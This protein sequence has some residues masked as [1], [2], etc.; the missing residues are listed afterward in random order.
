V[1]NSRVPTAE[2]DANWNPVDGGPGVTGYRN[3]HAKKNGTAG[4]LD[5]MQAPFD[6]AAERGMVG[7]ILLGCS[8]DAIRE[9]AGR[10]DIH[11]TL[12]QSAF[13]VLAALAAEDEPTNDVQVFIGKAKEMHLWAGDDAGDDGINTLFIAKLIGDLPHGES[14]VFHAKRVAE[15]SRLRQLQTSCLDVLRLVPSKTSEQLC[16]HL[17][18]R[19]ETIAK[20]CYAGPKVTMMDTIEATE[21]QWLW[22]DRFVR[23]K[24]NIISGEPGVGK[25]FLVCDII[26]RT[27]TGAAFPDTKH[28]GTTPGGVL[29]LNAEDDPSDTLRPRLEAA[30]ADL[31]RIAIV[32]AGNGSPI[33]NISRDIHR[34]RAAVDEVPDCKLVVIDPVGS[35][36]GGADSHNDADV[37]AALGGLVELAADTGVAVLL[38]AHLRK[39]GGRAITRTMGSVAFVGMA[40]SAWLVIEDPDD[41]KRKLLLRQ[42]LNVSRVTTG[43]A[44][45]LESHNGDSGTP[46]VAWE[47]DAVETTADEIFEKQEA[48]KKKNCK[49]DEAKAWLLV[50]LQK[51][52][53]MATEV[54]E[55]G[56]GAGYGEPLLRKALKQIGGRAA[57]L[58]FGGPWWWFIEDEAEGEPEAIDAPVDDENTP[59]TEMNVPYESMD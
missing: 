47:S 15:L 28:G 44:Y 29:L 30:G 54:F 22:R 38:V 13:D 50:R 36:I 49:L 31:S 32:G 23:R 40:R 26:A 25:T 11:D 34:I 51:Q 59:G 55:A 56:E 48:K 19:V 5:L 21:I 9:H 39:A 17:Y 35:Y 7:S 14:G 43:L 58:T 1:V 24:L 6:H 8:L 27:S 57:R 18:T 41:Q 3:G 45:R 53:M 16:E 12:N 42:K 33:T 46:Y 2:D 20:R 4:G 37:R 52:K 10:N